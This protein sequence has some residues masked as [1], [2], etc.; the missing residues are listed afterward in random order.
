MTEKKINNKFEFNIK[1]I[2]QN[3]FIPGTEYIL[4][5]IDNASDFFLVPYIEFNKIYSDELEMLRN[6]SIKREYNGIIYNE[7]Y[8]VYENV[9]VSGKNYIQSIKNDFDVFKNGLLKFA[10]YISEH[11]SEHLC[12]IDKQWYI[13]SIT[14]SYITGHRY[15]DKIFGEFKIPDN[16]ECSIR[17]SFSFT[18]VY[19]N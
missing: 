10:Y 4:F 19:P 12:G 15:F 18:D 2:S 13:K 11:Q 14:V 5:E 6:N 16:I 7:L 1:Y 3:D 9:G 17:E 8:T